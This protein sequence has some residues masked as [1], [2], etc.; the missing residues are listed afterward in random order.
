MLRLPLQGQ[1]ETGTL[2]S[3]LSTRGVP[4]PPRAIVSHAHALLP[5]DLL[6]SRALEGQGREGGLCL[7]AECQDQS[8]GEKATIQHSSPHPEYFA[9]ALPLDFFFP[10][11]NILRAYILALLCYFSPMGVLGRR[12]G[13][14]FPR[15]TLPEEVRM[16]L[17]HSANSP[18]VGAA[19]C[20]PVRSGLHAT[21]SFQTSQSAQPA[22]ASLGKPPAPPSRIPGS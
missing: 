7:Q 22:A 5:T 15:L 18:P 13:S 12:S 11:L 1:T 21:C 14:S 10:S 17:P 4:S 20:V 6:I 9:A 16:K 8:R 3:L 19:N 2:W